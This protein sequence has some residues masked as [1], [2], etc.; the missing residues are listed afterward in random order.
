MFLKEKLDNGE[1]TIVLGTGVSV[2]FGALSWN[3]LVNCMYE[4]LNTDKFDNEIKA[5]EK[6][7]N[8]NLCKIQ[9][10]KL[11]LLK[12]K[13]Y[14]SKTLYNGLYDKYLIENNYSETSIYIIF[15]LLT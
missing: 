9:Y 14:Y 2:P 4:R 7:G 10:I 1:I 3:K 15:D 5:F 11:E 6:I 13:L 12:D 8:D